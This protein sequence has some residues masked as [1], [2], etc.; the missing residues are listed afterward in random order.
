MSGVSGQPGLLPGGM[1]VHT[2][3]GCLGKPPG[4]GG[5]SV[6]TGIEPRVAQ[7]AR[8]VTTQWPGEGAGARWP[9]SLGEFLHLL[10]DGGLSEDDHLHAIT[11]RRVRALAIGL[12]ERQYRDAERQADGDEEKA[13][14]DA[15]HLPGGVLTRHRADGCH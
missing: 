13:V 9:F 1:P 2:I 12:G 14:H 10:A 11:R 7:L 15:R 3:A 6:F 5:Q 8:C 4:G